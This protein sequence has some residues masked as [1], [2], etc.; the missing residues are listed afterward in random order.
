MINTVKTYETQNNIYQLHLG[1]KV[2]AKT[3]Y[4]QRQERKEE[5]LYMAKQK[6]C[7]ITLIGL[8]VASSMLLNEG[9][10]LILSLCGVAAAFT[11]DHVLN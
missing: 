1:Y 10:F 9:M 6:A 11:K 4:E 2:T 5:L 3:T 7:G 8:G